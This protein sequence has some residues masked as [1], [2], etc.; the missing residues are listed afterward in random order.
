MCT[1]GE[2]LLGQAEEGGHITEEA[3]GGH[4]LAPGKETTS[5]GIWLPGTPS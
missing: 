2:T 5:L 1:D 4:S 3:V